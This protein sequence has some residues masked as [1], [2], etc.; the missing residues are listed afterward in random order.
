MDERGGSFNFANH[1]EQV[2]DWEDSLIIDVGPNDDNT[3]LAAWAAWNS[4]I[5]G[6]IKDFEIITEALPPDKQRRIALT[7]RDGIHL[8]SVPMPD[9]AR[10]LP[11]LGP[12]ASLSLAVTDRNTA[13]ATPQPA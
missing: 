3:G 10:V 8:G 7:V 1:L 13:T 11:V 12:T 9:S 4:E 2:P 5:P 6:A